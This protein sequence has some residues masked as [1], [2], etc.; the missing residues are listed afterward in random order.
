MNSAQP[1]TSENNKHSVLFCFSLLL[2]NLIVIT[3]YSNKLLILCR[4]EQLFVVLGAL[5]VVVAYFPCSVLTGAVL[6]ALYEHPAFE[7]GTD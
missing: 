1:P 7:Q 5:L 4:T 6:A 2:L 3:I